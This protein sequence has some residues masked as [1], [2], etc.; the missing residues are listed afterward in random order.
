[1]S[2]FK[3]YHCVKQFDITDCGA[4]CIATISRQYG[5][6]IPITKIREVAGTDTRGTN[7]F[8]VIKAARELGFSAKG[9]RAEKEHLT[10]ELP[11]PCIA[12]VIKGNLLHYVVIHEIKGKEIIIADP[13]EGIVKYTPEKFCEIWSGVLLLMVPG[14]KFEKR[15]ETTGLFTRFFG[16]LL[17]HK[18][19]LIEIFIASILY[20]VMGLA[21]AFYF[22]YLID[23][24]LVDGITKTLHIISTGIIILT[25]LKI[26]MNAFRRHLLVYLSQKIDISLILTYYQHVLELPMTFFDSRKVGEIIS[27]LSDASKI[28]N[29]ISGATITVMIDT[30]MVIVGAIVL[31]IQSSIL[32]GIA[33]IV[34]PFY[35]VAVWSF[36][37]PFREIHR[38]E[39]EQGAELQS[40]LVESISGAATI[41]A[42]NAEDEAN[43][44]TESRFIKFIKLIFKASWLRNLQSSIQVTL[45]SVSE[46]LII[47]IGGLQIIKG[48]LS[49]GQLITFNAILAYF[50]GPIQNLIELQPQLQEAFVASDRLGEILDLEIEKKDEKNKILIDR[51][52]GKFEIKNIEFSYGTREKVIK[53]I[54]F[55]IQP[56]EKVALVGESGSGK[57]TLAKLLLKYYLVQEGDILIDDYNIKD[58]SYR[59]LRDRIGYVPQDIFLFSGTI[60]ENI[61]FG[62]K[63]I[64]MEEI[65]DAAKKSRAHDF[66]NKLPLRYETH[67]GE[68]GSN[69]SGGQK[70]RIAIARAIL[71]KPDVLILD[72]ATSNL[73]TATERAI[74]ETINY[75][76]KGI[77][78]I[79]IAHRLSTILS[80]DKIIL[81]EDGMIKEIGSHQDLLALRGD[82]YKLWQSQS[83]D[84]FEK[85]EDVS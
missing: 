38:K 85:K 72:E 22:K 17:P 66:I 44:E 71:K 16:L 70:Q 23:S 25:I 12:H 2:I 51:M 4:A 5:L 56:G 41:K 13:A 20:T 47:W 61:A 34:I 3:K 80:C 68:R 37:R 29:A 50:Y 74:H 57:T 67:V 59:S 36:N 53:N 46:V 77:T 6:K 83:L 54:S 28:R 73:D 65:V 15:D 31:Y 11:L 69:L 60:R 21:G 84:E 81:L 45:T 40:Y 58:L 82:Y 42:F 10:K 7:A 49:I 35:I 75:V 62:M 19:L 14:E 9:V 30:L 79:I 63:N 27:R 43:L 48:N 8:G 52:Q 26:V 32:F 33:S 18:R 78:T 55:D 39:M 64:S 76:S 24:I 1:M